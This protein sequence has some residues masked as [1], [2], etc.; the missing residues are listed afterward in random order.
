MSKSA[1]G[2]KEHLPR[3]HEIH[4]LWDAITARLLVDS[5]G[6]RGGCWTTPSDTEL[7]GGCKY[8]RAHADAGWSPS[9]HREQNVLTLALGSLGVGDCAVP[10][11]VEACIAGSR[12]F[13]FMDESREAC[14]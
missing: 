10:N 12:A 13:Y 1:G 14:W 9:L 3:F 4:N 2:R 7:V 11:R 8:I 6:R 5:P